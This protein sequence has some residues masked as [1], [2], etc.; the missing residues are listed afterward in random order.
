MPSVDKP[1]ATAIT[2]QA[3]R[4]IPSL[5][6]PVDLFERVVDPAEYEMA[7]Y[8]ESLTNDRLRDQ[9]GELAL[10]KAEDRISGCGTTPIMAAFT[11]IGHASRFTDGSYGVYYA[12]NNS[13]TALAETTYHRAQF[14]RA[15]NEPDTRIYMR[16]YVGSVI[17]PMLDITANQYQSLH[18]ADNY[19]VSQHYAKQPRQAGAYG[20]LFNSVRYR[21][22]LC[23]AVFRP[24]ALTP[25]IQAAHYEY[26]YSAALQSIKYVL[27]VS[28][29]KLTPPS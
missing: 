5:F 12:A 22:G 6:P 19:Q 14:Y 20:L 13:E 24:C 27:L 25:V 9:V 21:N 8:I 17:Q 18:N 1:I 2:W 23:V 29:V 28:E 16:E 11:H 15:T 26:F 3:R 10:V 4:I 7:F